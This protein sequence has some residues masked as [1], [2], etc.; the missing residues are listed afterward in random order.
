MILSIIICSYN[1]ANYIEAA[2]DSL[3]HQS[4]NENFEIIIVDNNSTDNTAEVYSNWRAAHSN[5]NFQYITET[6]QGASFARNTG[7]AMAKGKW[8]CF[9]D[10]DAIALQIM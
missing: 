4:S 10:D 8:L 2:L 3:Y 7:A 1:R 6:K 9:M 5:G